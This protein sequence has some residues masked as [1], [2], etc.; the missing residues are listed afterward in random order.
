[1][2]LAGFL[3]ALIEPI[4]SFFHV[5]AD[6]LE[7]GISLLPGVVLHVDHHVMAFFSDSLEAGEFLSEGLFGGAKLVER[8]VD[9]D[10]AAS[11]VLKRVVEVGEIGAKFVDAAVV[12]INNILYVGG[13]ATC[14]LVDDFDG[15]FRADD[16]SP[17]PVCFGAGV[18]D[19]IPESVGEGA[20]A[21]PERGEVLD[22]RGDLVEALLVLRGIVD[23][24]ARIL[25]DLGDVR[26]KGANGTD[27]VVDPRLEI[28]DLLAGSI[29]VQRSG[30]GI[31]FHVIAKLIDR[32]RILCHL[33]LVMLGLLV[34]AKLTTAQLTEQRT[35]L[36]DLALK[37]GGSGFLTAALVFAAVTVLATLPGLGV[38]GRRGRLFAVGG[39][40]LRRRLLWGWLFMYRWSLVDELLISWLRQPGF[41]RVCVGWWRRLV[42]AAS[43]HGHFLSVR[44]VGVTDVKGTTGGMGRRCDQFAPSSA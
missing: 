5:L 22:D 21:I 43:K 44:I 17:K 41:V 37:G 1:M 6:L 30:L 14:F 16:V 19:P 13:T 42:L 29:F 25:K 7:S 38:I 36:I 27:A 12:A 39:N 31:L 4:Y 32:Q 24:L 9:V 3:D 10:E 34:G 11:G 8:R 28:V 18:V 35:Q 23:L 2:H 20:G 26:L 40:S 15:V 33:A